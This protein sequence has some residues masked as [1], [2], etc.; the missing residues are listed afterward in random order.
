MHNIVLKQIQKYEMIFRWNAAFGQLFGKHFIYL[1]TYLLS[2]L[3]KY[4]EIRCKFS[5]TGVCHKV[6]TA[7]GNVTVEELWTTLV[8]NQL[9][10]N[11]LYA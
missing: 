4:I 11:V 10:V 3:I 6:D 8:S 5:M 1:L 9:L 7:H 2:C